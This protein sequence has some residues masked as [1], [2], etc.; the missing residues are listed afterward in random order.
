MTSC[1]TIQRLLAFLDDL[2]VLCSPHRVANAH[3]VLQQ[4]LWG[5]LPNFGPSREDPNLEQG[6]RGTQRMARSDSCSSLG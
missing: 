3:I 1:F 2:Y 5:A 6:R 4:A